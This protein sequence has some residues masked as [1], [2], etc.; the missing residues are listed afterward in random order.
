M[1]S[2]RAAMRSVRKAMWNVRK[3][4]EVAECRLATTATAIQLLYA[5]DR[6]RARHWII[7]LTELFMAKH[8]P[9]FTRLVPPLCNPGLQNRRTDFAKVL[10]RVLTEQD[11]QKQLVSDRQLLPCRL[12][13]TLRRFLFRSS[14][15]FRRAPRLLRLLRRS[16]RHLHHRLRL[17]AREIVVELARSAVEHVTEEPASHRPHRL[18]HARHP[19]G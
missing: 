13:P 15:T 11:I 12:G 6:V 4:A 3:S 9:C 7:R 5:V 17:G 10:V 1:H 16:L 18:P 14:S 2:A 19:G 8:P